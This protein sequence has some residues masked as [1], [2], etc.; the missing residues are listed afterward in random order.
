MEIKEFPI[1]TQVGIFND[2]DDLQIWLNN[3]EPF[4]YCLIRHA[5]FIYTPFISEILQRYNYL[6][7]GIYSFSNIFDELPNWW[8]EAIEY[9]DSQMPEIIKEKQRIEKAKNASN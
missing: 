9:I 7:K 4:D 8:I 2:D 1:N 5:P 3:G 6:K